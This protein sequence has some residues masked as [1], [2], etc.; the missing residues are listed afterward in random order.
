MPAKEAKLAIL[1]LLASAALAQNRSYCKVTFSVVT[2]DALNN[3]TQGLS[4]KAREWFQKKMTKKYPDVCYSEDAVPVVL[5]FSSKPAVHH[6]VR[7]YSTTT[8]QSN[9]VQGTVTDANPGSSTYGQQIGQVNG[10]VETSSTM[11]H[12]VPYEMNYDVLYLSVEEGKADGTWQVRHNFSGKTLHPT[13]YG[14][15]TRNCHPGYALIEDA[16]RWLHD[17]GLSDARQTVIP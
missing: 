16:V 7:T 9:P 14:F 12:A 4:P 2:K 3:Y 13:L 17:G 5:F 8:T 11:E 15:C 6:G 10:T 1:L